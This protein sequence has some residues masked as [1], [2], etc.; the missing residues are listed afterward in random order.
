GELNKEGNRHGSGTYIFP[1]GKKLIG[2]WE[3]GEYIDNKL[4][5]MNHYTI[6]SSTLDF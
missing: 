3:N 2:Q 6:T 1:D 5:K 4:K